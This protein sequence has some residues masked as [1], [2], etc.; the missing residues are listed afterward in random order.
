MA[1]QNTM[2]RYFG[3]SHKIVI[4]RRR[5]AEMAVIYLENGGRN[6]THGR[7]ASDAVS[8]AIVLHDE[9]SPADRRTL[10]LN[11]LTSFRR[12]PQR[13]SIPA[14][15]HRADELFASCIRSESY[16]F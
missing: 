13:H 1:V 8:N 15:A 10:S 16:S 14:A 5:L 9:P 7:P 6:T 2:R 3:G 4:V 11:F 12:P